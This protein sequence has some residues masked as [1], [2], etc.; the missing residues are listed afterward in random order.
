MAPRTIAA[1]PAA[2]LL[3]S[4]LLALLSSPALAASVDVKPGDDI[5]SLT[6]SLGPG[7]V[8]TF[9]D[10]TYETTQTLTWSGAGTE[11]SPIL[12]R[13]A[14]GA[15][16]RIVMSPGNGYSAVVQVQDASW[17][18]VEGLSFTVDAATYD[19][20]SNEGLRVQNS[21]HVTI[22]GN[23]VEHVPSTGI[24]LDGDV[25]GAEV[26]RNHVHDLRVGSAIAAG[27][28]DASC[29]TQNSRIA[30][31]W[32]HDVLNQ[33]RYGVWL[34]HGCQG[35]RIV[36]NVLYTLEGR[37][38]LVQSTEGGAQN[39]VERNVIFRARREALYVVGAAV[40]RNNLVFGIDGIGIRSAGNDRGTLENVVIT[41]NTV[42]DT[43][44]WGVQIDDWAGKAGMVFANNA[45]ANPTGYAWVMKAEDRD[46]GNYVSA[47]VVT[48]LVDGPDPD[49]GHF[50]SG[51]GFRDFVSAD[52]WDFYPSPQSSL[53]G[54]GDPGGDAWVPP[55]DFNTVPRDGSAPDAGAYEWIDDG[56]PGWVVREGFKEVGYTDPAAEQVGG[57]CDKDSAEQSGQ[58]AL[59]LS[60]ALLLAVARRRRR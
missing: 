31:N 44:G 50:V 49:A 7:D 33:D 37:G 21:D 25:T 9:A 39:V 42:A 51:G 53:L 3:P 1:S 36:D 35:N 13:A 58:A 47:N 48:G 2:R 28:G 38:L 57:C 29:W 15:A 60:P 59:W 43:L 55:E 4:P 5:V 19:T 23:T 17:L 34:S 41:H 11:S 26:V 45:I 10:G 6:A 46:E 40:V 27:C 30:E 22:V 16:P 8:I 56:N 12:L 52:D 20:G 18:T 32:L 54:A 24:R 14:E